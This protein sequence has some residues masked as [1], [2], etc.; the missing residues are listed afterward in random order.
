MRHLRSILLATD[1]YLTGHGPLD[2]AA[3]LSQMFGA[4]VQLFHVLKHHEDL[5]LADFSLTEHASSELMALKNQLTAKGAE[6]A[7]LPVEF[8][9]P[10]NSIVRRAEKLDV[11]LI[12]LGCNPRS[13]S[14]VFSAGPIAE[15]VIQ[16]ARQP[17]LVVAHD[18]DDESFQTILCPVDHSDASR[19]GLKNAIRLAHVFGSEVV[20]MTAIPEVNWLAAAI[21]SGHLADAKWKFEH[22]WQKEFDHFISNVSFGQ[23]PWKSELRRGEPHQQIIASAAEHKAG[24]IAMGAIGRSGL[25]RALVGGVTRSILRHLPCS[26]LIV[27]AEDLVDEFTEEDAKVVE[28]LF[29][30]AQAL[31]AVESFDAAVAKFDQVLAHNPFHEAALVHRAEAL[32]RLGEIDR[33]ARSH[34]RAAALHRSM[35]HAG[36]PVSPSPSAI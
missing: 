11:D 17:A 18:Y 28:L 1:L 35:R 14:G 30:E 25:V 26:I 16:H 31:M 21:E 10:A 29:A 19:R 32:M 6:A 23:V 13:A 24:L 8:G 12:L 34:R 33:A 15:A 20:V 27:K 5:H 7:T 36:E 3:R 9:S 2:V 4:R 22:Q